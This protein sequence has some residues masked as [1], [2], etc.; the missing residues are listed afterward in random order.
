MNNK[1]NGS[2][3]GNKCDSIIGNTND[4]EISYNNIIGSITSNSNLGSITYNINSGNIESCS[5]GISNC[6]IAHNR[7]NGYISGVYVAD[8]TDSIVNK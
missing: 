1:I 2:I 7:N 4:G 5:S 6:E 3:I 8:V